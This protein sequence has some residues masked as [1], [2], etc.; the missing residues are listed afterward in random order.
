VNQAENRKYESFANGI[1][2]LDSRIFS[3]IVVKN[4]GGAILAEAVRPEMKNTLGTLSQRT[5]GMVGMW[6]ILAYNAVMRLE[7]ARSKTKYLTIGRETTKGMLFP[8][9][10]FEGVMIGLTIELR[11]EATEIYELVMKFVDESI[12]LVKA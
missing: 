2:S 6:G 7:K 10:I 9:N 5:E 3:S 12:R 8:A 1:L 4:P 11:T